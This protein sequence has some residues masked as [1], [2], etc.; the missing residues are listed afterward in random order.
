MSFEEVV[1]WILAI[2]GGASTLRAILGP[3]AWD[4]ILGFN[5]LSSK[6][7]MIIV[8]FAL[9][10]QK[11]YLLDIALIYALFGFVGTVMIARF[12]EKGDR[13]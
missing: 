8:L 10:L 6:M 9:L 12:V 4:R 2:L 5:L 7:V 1:L 11:S 13:L 3:T